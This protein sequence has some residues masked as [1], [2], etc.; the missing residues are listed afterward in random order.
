MAVIGI[1]L[2]VI[3]AGWA[4][5]GVANVAMMASNGSTLM[6]FGLIFNMALFVLPGLVVA[7]LGALLFRKA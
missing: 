7:G 2:G 1:F 5:L 3:G 4:V 6:A